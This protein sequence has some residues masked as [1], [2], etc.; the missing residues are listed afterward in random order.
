M[1]GQCRCPR[2]DA[3]NRVDARF[4][5]SC[6]AR[7]A[8]T[9]GSKACPP[10]HT[11]NRTD[12]KLCA[13]YLHRFSDA[14]IVRSPLIFAGAGIAGVI[15]LVLLCGPLLKPGFDTIRG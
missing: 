3:L 5:V 4:C 12:T 14:P 11:A 1:L 2:A 7:L 10:C 15:V 9:D 6:Q 8:V 13:V